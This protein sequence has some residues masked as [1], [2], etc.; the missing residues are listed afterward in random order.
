MT[1]NSIEF[2]NA[3][4]RLENYLKSITNVSENTNLISY[5]EK[6]LP[7]KKSAECATVRKY[8]YAVESHGVS[9]GAVKPTVPK[10]W[11]EWLNKALSYCKNNS[12]EVAKR[13][14]SAY[15]SQKLDASQKGRTSET[16]GSNSSNTYRN[17]FDNMYGYSKPRTAQT[18]ALASEPTPKNNI[19]PSP[20]AKELQ[21]ELKVMHCWPAADYER[22][23]EVAAEVIKKYDRKT[24]EAMQNKYGCVKKYSRLNLWKRKEAIWELAQRIIANLDEEELDYLLYSR[25]NILLMGSDT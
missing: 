8:K 3:Y 15:D 23:E 5:F 16:A 4:N 6:I 9:P 19:T 21:I 25:A 11:I 22:L 2:V 7:E 14:Q 20:I 12:E 24:I 18:I 17:Y 1:D 13:V 10:E